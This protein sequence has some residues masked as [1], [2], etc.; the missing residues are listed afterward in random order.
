MPDADVTVNAVFAEENPTPAKV[1][2]VAVTLEG[3][4]VSVTFNVDKGFTFNNYEGITDPETALTEITKLYTDLLTG[5][6]DKKAAAAKAI[7]NGR[8]RG[9]LL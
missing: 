2:D 5:S 1:S 8:H 6:E 9:L 3:E 4:A 7:G